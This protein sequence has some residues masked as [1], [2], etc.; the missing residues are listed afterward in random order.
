MQAAIEKAEQAAIEKADTLIEAMGW[1]REFRD[2][3]TVIKLG[4]SVMEDEDALRHLLVDIVFMETVGM[5]P[6]VVHGGGAAISRAMA[7]AG[8]EPNF[9]QGRRYTDDATLSIVEKVLAGQINEGIATQIEAFGGRAMPLNFVGDTDNNVL[10][11][12]RI[13]LTGDGGEQ[14][15]LGHVGQV[16][17]VDRDIID[18]LCYAGQVPVIPSMCVDDDG[19][20]YNVNADTAAMAVAQAVG[21]EKLVFLSDVNGVRQDKDDPNSLI[22]TLTSSKAKEL[23]A[24]GVIASGMIPKVEACLA[25]LEKG[26][27]KIHII[28][29]RLRHSLLLEVYTNTGVGTEIIGEP[30][31]G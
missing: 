9:V 22:H 3:V 16:T 28:D 19:N 24:S 25:T 18:N 13:A 10:Y 6:I 14:L 26:V 7:E 8:I 1:I 20:K 21:A 31:A 30:A 15:D 27:R 12:E 17:R 11:G 5:R 4:G 2:K 23:I 29:G